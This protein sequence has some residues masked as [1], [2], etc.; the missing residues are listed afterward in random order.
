MTIRQD[1]TQAVSGDQSSQAEET[2]LRIHRAEIN[3][4][5]VYMPLEAGAQAYLSALDLEDLYLKQGAYEGYG[6][7]PAFFEWSKDGLET[8]KN[9]LP[10]MAG[11]GAFLQE[12]EGRAAL[13]G[14]VTGYDRVQVML[15]A[16][17]ATKNN[18]VVHVDNQTGLRGLQ[19]LTGD[20]STLWLPD[21]LVDMKSFRAEYDE[22]GRMIGNHLQTSFKEQSQLQQIP[23][24][25]MSIHKG[26][27]YANPLFHSAPGYNPGL[28]FY[29]GTR[30]I[31]TFDRL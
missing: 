18:M 25:H 22:Q 31:A 19:T 9:E 23:K 26:Q 15:R 20:V 5:S 28:G 7:E 12:I 13:F 27:N 2:L 29:P 6:H 14:R 1:F 8:I 10:A 21:H 24:H 17:S 30:L 4:A 16:L 3:L 11:R